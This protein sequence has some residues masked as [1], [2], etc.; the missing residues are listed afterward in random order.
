M[1]LIHPAL[2][3]ALMYC[4]LCLIM[5]YI[6]FELKKYNLEEK[7]YLNDCVHNS[8]VLTPESD[9]DLWERFFCVFIV[10]LVDVLTVPKGPNNTILFVHSPLI[11]HIVK[12]C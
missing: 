2:S 5:E 1:Y 6:L 7:M 4:N 3:Y 10:C 9:S 8:N 12:A 11:V